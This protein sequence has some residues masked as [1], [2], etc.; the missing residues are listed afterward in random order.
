VDL[1]GDI[2]ILSVFPHDQRPQV[3]GVLLQALARKEI[4]LQGLAS[5]PSAVSTIVPSAETEAAI[6]TFFEA[7]TFPA[8]HSPSDWYAAYEGKEHLLK[9]IIASYQ[10]KIIRIYDIVQQSDLDLW[11]L[12]VNQADLGDLGV[13]LTALEQSEIRMP[14]VIALP[15]PGDRLSFSFCLPGEQET[16]IREVLSS[17]LGDTGVTYYSE[18]GALYIH[19]PHFGDRYGIAHALV[20]ALESEGV[21]LL[22]LGCTVSSISAIIKEAD[23]AAA[24]QTLEAT[25][26]RS[27]T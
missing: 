4:P 13:A 26:Q 11:S 21:S 23:L 17:H 22:A 19:G 8:Y 3:P 7:F 9:K 15:T 5:S 10:E 16:Q 27:S 24:V 1:R 18:V 2:S 14:F 20:K 6:D 25:F 12:T